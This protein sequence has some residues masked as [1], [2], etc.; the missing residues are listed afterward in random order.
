MGATPKQYLLVD[1]Y[2]VAH[3]WPQLRKVLSR[4]IDAAAELLVSRL[5]ILHDPEACE[6][7]IVFDGRGDRIDFAQPPGGKLPCVMYSPAGRSADA[8][9]EQIVYNAPDGGAFT[10]AT[11]D[12]AL[13]LSAVTRGAHVI[14]PEALLEWLDREGAKTMPRDKRSDSFGNRLF[15]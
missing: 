1:G 7:T 5:A 9:I 12:N 6:V 11:R 2:N 15:G 8:L 13:C 14:S 3:A 10:V 4:D